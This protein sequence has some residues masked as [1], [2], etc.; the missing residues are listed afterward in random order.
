MIEAYSRV[1]PGGSG[2]TPLSLAAARNQK[3]STIS[4]WPG[5]SSVTI[6]CAYVLTGTT[7]FGVPGN[8]TTL[9]VSKLW[10]ITGVSSP[11]KRHFPIA[12]LGRITVISP[13][14]GTSIGGLNSY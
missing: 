1:T 10:T 14:G 4:G 13:D 3:T 12:R 8:L 2:P 11:V 9:I 7:I 6:K 5:G